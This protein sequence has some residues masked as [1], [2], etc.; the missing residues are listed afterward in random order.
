MASMLE[1]CNQGS[2]SGLIK[3]GDG[4]RQ[5]VVMINVRSC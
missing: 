3:A 1:G 2:S 4:V 5:G